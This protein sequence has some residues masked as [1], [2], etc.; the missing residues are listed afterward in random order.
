M[1]S[2]IPPLRRRSSVRLANVTSYY[3][4]RSRARVPC[5]LA[6]AASRRRLL[7]LDFGCPTLAIFWLGWV[8]SSLVEEYPCPILSSRAQPRD[9]RF[10]RSGRMHALH[11]TAPHQNCHP[12]RSRGICG[13]FAVAGC[14][15]ST[16]PPSHQNCHPERSRGI[17]GSFA[18][19]G[20]ARSTQPPLIR[21]VI[22]SAAEGSA[23]RSQWQ[24]VVIG[25]RN[26]TV[27]ARVSPCETEDDSPALQRWVA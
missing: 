22:P 17:R 23:V 14:T 25:N 2:T 3:R 24:D 27:N 12:E 6:G 18:V 26:R 16:Q 20:C 1:P 8:F 15:R 21:I 7:A 10:V 9:L 13:S 5:C 19:A 11:P 4:A